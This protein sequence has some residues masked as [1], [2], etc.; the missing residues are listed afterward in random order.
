MSFGRSDRFADN[1]LEIDDRYDDE[2]GY[3]DDAR[4]K[5]K[6]RMRGTW[7]NGKGQVRFG[8]PGFGRFELCVVCVVYV[9]YV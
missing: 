9:V 3:L 8:Q 6:R 5:E 7:G 2:Y 1:E 4:E